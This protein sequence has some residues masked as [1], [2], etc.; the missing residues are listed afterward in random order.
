MQVKTNIRAGKGGVS[1]GGKSGGDGIS[2]RDPSKP[3]SDD[4]LDTPEVEVYYPPVS[5]CTGL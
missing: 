2:G 3:P 4:S 1:G 5:R